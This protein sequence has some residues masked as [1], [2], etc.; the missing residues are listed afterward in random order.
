MN[1]GMYTYELRRQRLTDLYRNGPSVIQRQQAIEQ[2]PYQHS[3]EL[4]LDPPKLTSESVR[5]WSD[6]NRVYYHPKSVVQLNEYE[7]NSTI[8]P[9][10]NWSAGEELF[11]SL[12]KDQDLLDRDLRPFAEEA[13]QLQGIQ[14]MA[15]IDDAWGGFAARYMDRLRDEYGKTT[16]WFWGLED[17]IKAIPK[18]KTI[19]SVVPNILLILNSTS[20]SRNSQIPPDLSQILLLSHPSS[21]PSSFR[22]RYR[23]MSLSI[24]VQ[25]GTSLHCCRPL[26][27]L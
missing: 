27:R 12:D 3:L 25:A 15:G 19:C 18:V 2:S 7:L 9:F 22:Q 24:L 16:V 4:G 11:T 5:Y 23:D 8:M 1:Y 26:S 13:D 10:E 17:G 20:A 21:F 6:F 14:I